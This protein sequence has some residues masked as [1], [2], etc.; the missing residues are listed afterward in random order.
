[1]NERILKTRYEVRGRVTLQANV[2][3]NQIKTAKAEGNPNPLPFDEIVYCNIGNPQ[4]LNQKPLTFVRQVTAM[5]EYPALMD[6]PGVSLPSD[7]VAR[8]RR[9]LEAGK[10][11][12]PYTHSQGLLLIRKDI[13]Q[14]LYE[15]DGHVCD[16]DS[17]F[18]TDGASTGVKLM[19]NILIRNK[20][21]GIMTPVPQY[22]LYSAG[23]AL[24]GGAPVNYYLDEANGWSLD[25]NE[26]VRSYKEARDNGVNV[27]AL[28]VINPNNPTGRC[29]SLE[30][31]SEIITFCIEHNVVLLADEVYQENIYQEGVSFTSFR[32]LAHD[33]GNAEKLELVSFH[34]VSKGV[35][36]ECGKRGGFFNVDGILPS[37][38]A[39]LYKMS[40]ISLCPNTIGQVVTDIMVRPP[41]KGDP[42]YDLYQSERSAIMVSLKRRAK[43]LG[44]A[45]ETLEGVHVVRPNSA[46]YLFPSIQIPDKAIAEAEEMNVRPDAFYCLELLKS[47]GICIVPGS[48][49]GQK[50]GTF[51]FRTSFLPPEDQIANVSDRFKRFHAEF[52]DRFR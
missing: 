42:S 48:G 41:K 43:Q 38:V 2:Y 17:I 37:V 29:L 35:F 25:L 11:T 52:M 8:A 28:V 32:K 15:R 49:F 3:Q 12:G 36:G 24:Y 4:S 7:A 10:G 39:E 23:L 26:L 45:L 50:D 31:M 47:T 46:M 18:M 21:D 5:M 30:V 1:M 27:R 14:F 34:S 6:M 44:D 13:A 22:P 33:M 19:L 20:H 51:H 16:P 40:S 9:L